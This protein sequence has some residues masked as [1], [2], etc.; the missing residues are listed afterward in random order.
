MEFETLRPPLAENA[1]PAIYRRHLARFCAE[2]MDPLEPLYAR[3]AQPVCSPQKCPL[4]SHDL[5]V[6]FGGIFMSSSQEPSGRGPP[7]VLCPGC[8]VPMTLQS[9]EPT[10]DTLQTATFKCERCGTETKRDFKHDE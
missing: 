10:T 4:S 6:G 5:P 3:P 9:S 2:D 8:N 1:F 7:V